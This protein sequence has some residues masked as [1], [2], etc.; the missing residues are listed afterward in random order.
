MSAIDLIYSIYKKI[1][2]IL[3]GYNEILYMKYLDIKDLLVL[4]DGKYVDVVKPNFLYVQ[5]IKRNYCFRNVTYLEQIILRSIIVKNIYNDYHNPLDIRLEKRLFN[6]LFLKYILKE[7][8]EKL[9]NIKLL[10]RLS[11]PPVNKNNDIELSLDFVK[12]MVSGVEPANNISG[13]I[14]KSSNSLFLSMERKINGD[15]KRNVY[16]Q[17]IKFRD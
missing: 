5:E 8:K 2:T 12:N 16:E 6:N 9:S 14:I 11:N 13:D 3:V 10:R 15:D 1:N 4:N 7:K 17:R